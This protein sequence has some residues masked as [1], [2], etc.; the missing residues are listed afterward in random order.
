MCTQSGSPRPA[1]LDTPSKLND[2][3]FALL[4]ADPQRAGELASSALDIATQAQDASGRIYAHLT[5]ALIGFRQSSIE[6]AVKHL[7]AA[8]QQSAMQPEERARCLIEH[9][10]AQWL[11][12]QGRQ[13]EALD[14]L[15]AL[16]ARA[17]HRPVLDAFYT[18]TALGTVRCIQ[19]ENDRA[20]ADFYEAL[21]L[22]E[23]CSNA[24][25]EVNAL[26]NLGSLQLDLYN[27]EDARP[28]LERCLAGALKVASRRQ[29]I[30]AAGNLLQCYC[31]KGLA[32]EALA[33]ARLH[34]IPLITAHDVPSLQRDEEIAHALIDNRLFDEAKEYLARKPQDDGLT[35]EVSA[36]R[37]WLNARL[38]LA[39]DSPGEALALCLSQPSDED[40]NSNVPLDLLRLAQLGADAARCVG[41]YQTAYEQQAK[42]F[43]INDELLGRAAKA[44]FISLQIEHEVQR[45]RNERDSARQ[46]ARRLTEINQSLQAQIEENRTLHAQL[47][48]LALED[49]LTGLHNRRFLFDTGA[50]L[51]ALA[52]RQKTPLAVA[53]IDLDHFKV[54]N[55]RYGHDC[56]DRVLKRFAE[57]ACQM[58]RSSDILCR[59]GGE[60]FVIVFATAGAAT[61]AKRVSE[62]LASFQALRFDG[63]GVALL[64]CSFS[65]GVSELGADG[66]DL[67]ELLRRAD[68]ALYR[69]KSDGRS[70][71]RRCSELS[72]G[73]GP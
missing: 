24:S 45:T 65:A 6:I 27:L 31:A 50:R 71:V 39:E 8:E 33:L 22:A 1:P 54:V 5:L 42:A 38:L 25:V 46:L 20:L 17:T 68:L 64:A 7:E 11:R 49:P 43:R 62:L 61:A 16:H 37:T 23:R 55:D 72:V 57:L 36:Y 56:G 53:L 52:H 12:R 9:A 70:C 66:E 69:A 18:L 26:N 48:A 13:R 34:L 47:H 51:I 58:I 19:G 41:Q 21:A 15:I 14:M 67:P 30:F 32:D 73:S 10:R 29:T 35:N 60:E 63:P 4:L 40:G 59:L 3:A 2:E 28:L 44:R